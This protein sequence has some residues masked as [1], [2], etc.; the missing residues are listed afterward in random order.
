MKAEPYQRTPER[1]AHGNEI[2]EASAKTGL[3]AVP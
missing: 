3:N 1:E 2:P